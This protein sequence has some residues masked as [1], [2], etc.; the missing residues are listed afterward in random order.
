MSPTDA[1][2]VEQ[3]A[4]PGLEPADVKPLRPDGK[5]LVKAS[6]N[7][8]ADELEALKTLA[9]R[10]GTTATQVVRQSL[11][12]ESYLQKIVD[13]GGTIMAKVGRRAQDLIFSQMQLG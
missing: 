1:T 8:P 12:T 6:F 9:D 13:E 11:A 10:R 7:L 2:A 5:R 3:G 4:A